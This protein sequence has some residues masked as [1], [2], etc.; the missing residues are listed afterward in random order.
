MKKELKKADAKLKI[1]RETLRALEQD[2]L[3]DVAGALTLAACPTNNHF[4]CTTG[5]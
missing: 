2:E 3:S 4:N 1:H 5:C